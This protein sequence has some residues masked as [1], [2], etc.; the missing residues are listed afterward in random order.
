MDESAQ[1]DIQRCFAR[2]VKYGSPSLGLT[3]IIKPCLSVQGEQASGNISIVDLLQEVD[4]ALLLY[5]VDDSSWMR[6]QA[7]DLSHAF[8]LLD[9][10]N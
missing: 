5:L 6:I 10:L 3:Y 7:A 9:D 2:A 4:S 1:V 8:H